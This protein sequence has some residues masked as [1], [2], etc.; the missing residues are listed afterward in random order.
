[1]IS[2][3][4]PERKL[5]LAVADDELERRRVLLR[6]A[7]ETDHMRGY[8]RLFH[9]HVT[10]AGSGCDFDFLTSGKLDKKTP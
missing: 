3:N 10:Q 8:L 9:D 7:P 5:T 1:M 6:S 4:V 2:L